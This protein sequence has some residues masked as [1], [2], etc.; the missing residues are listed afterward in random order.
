MYQVILFCCIEPQV[1]A[2]VI[3]IDDLQQRLEAAVMK[4]STCLVGPEAVQW[5]G[6]VTLIGS[7]VGLEGIN[8]DLV[9]RMQIPSRFACYGLDMAACTRGLVCKESLPPLRGFGIETPWRRFWR[10][11][12]E[13]IK[14]QCRERGRNQIRRTLEMAEALR[15]SNRKLDCII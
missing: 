10:R 15:S 12:R 13:L 7:P 14:M 1:E 9:P 6:P 4:E 11:N 8:A 2:L 5:G 3:V